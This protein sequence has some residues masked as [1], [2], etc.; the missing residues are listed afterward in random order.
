MPTRLRFLYVCDQRWDALDG[1][2]AQRRRCAACSTT[3][4][5]LDAMTGEQQAALLRGAEAAAT[6]VCVSTTVPREAA[7][8]C[9]AGAPT[10]PAVYGPPEG[11]PLAGM[12][13]STRPPEGAL[14]GRVAPA[15]VAPLRP[16]PE[17][18]GA[19]TLAHAPA[20]VRAAIEALARELGLEEE[21]GRWRFG[22]DAPPLA[23]EV[24]ATPQG[25]GTRVVVR[26][27]PTAVN[28][29]G[30]SAALAS[31][32]L[33]LLAVAIGGLAWATGS[34]IGWLVA[35][36]SLAAG[37]ASPWLGERWMALR[38]WRARRA[39]RRWCRGWQARFWPAL[40]GRLAEPRVYR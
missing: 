30:E 13:M 8:A 33:V 6:T 36:G 7:Q 20:E 4:H 24:E 2:D 11:V 18:V 22:S 15:E 1:E 40:A 34:A 29:A 14:V 16:E 27:A 32:G 35:G 39:A 37:L 25:E 26:A 21:V 23:G 31:T 17:E 3:V 12:V 10:E 19:R 28:S 5:N 9:R 38:A